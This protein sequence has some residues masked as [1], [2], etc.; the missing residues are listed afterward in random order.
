MRQHRRI[1]REAS[2]FAR[3]GDR[4]EIRPNRRLPDFTPG[5]PIDSFGA[6]GQFTA[7]PVPASVQPTP[8]AKLIK[9]PDV[10]GVGIRCPRGSQLSRRRGGIPCIICLR[11]GEAVSTLGGRGAHD[12]IDPE[13]SYEVKAQAPR[14][15]AT[16]M[17]AASARPSSRTL[18]NR[19]AW[20]GQRRMLPIGQRFCWPRKGQRCAST[21]PVQ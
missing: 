6:G 19:S 15:P 17:R 18:A 1:Y 7:T 8:A 21:P 16:A 13:L 11:L 5:S 2:I 10:L 20:F 12:V 14:I 4:E 9:S 3:A